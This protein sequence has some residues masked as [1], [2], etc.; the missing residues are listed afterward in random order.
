DAGTLFDHPLLQVD[1]GGRAA[2]LEPDLITF[3]LN[4]RFHVVEIKSFAI[5]DGQA[6]GGK[7]A[8]AVTQAAVYVLALRQLLKEFGYGPETVADEVVLVCPE[9]FANRATAVIVDI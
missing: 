1:V 2:F 4:G 3:Q 8:A 7:V 6:D 5:I 9:N